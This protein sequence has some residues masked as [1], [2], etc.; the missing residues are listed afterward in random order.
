MTPPDI[1]SSQEITEGQKI[2][3]YSPNRLGEYELVS[4][5][6]GQP[7]TVANKQAWQEID[8][9]ITRSRKLVQ[10]GHRSC[11]HFYMT[12]ALMDTGLLAGYTGQPRWKVALH[13]IPFFF[14]RI[15]PATLKKYANL[16]KV[17]PDDLTMG[18]LRPPDP[19]R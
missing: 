13:L 3:R 17:S 15:S 14:R 16:F 9:Q 10:A 18:R 6:I 1:D 7:V 2:V 8:R 11:L 4:D 5:F 12:A 19:D